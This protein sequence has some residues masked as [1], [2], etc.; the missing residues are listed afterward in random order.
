MPPGSQPDRP[1]ARGSVRSTV[2][3]E[4][5]VIAV[6]LDAWRAAN[7]LVVAILTFV[8]A[9]RLSE[10]VLARRNTRRLLAKG[11]VEVGRQHYLPMVVLHAC[12]LLGLWILA[13]A[14]GVSLPLLGIFALL[15]CA[16]LWVLVS[17]GER[18]TTRVIV[19]PGAPLVAS[20]PYRFLRH[21]NYCIVA[22]EIL[23]LPLAFGLVTFAVVFTAFNAII[24]SLRIRQEDAALRRGQPLALVDQ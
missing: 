11:A 18:W 7:P 9:Q 5:A 17:L 8:S 2:G 22:A 13:P 15:Q 1:D 24:L 6:L 16:R 20:G 14:G 3:F 4:D 10:L 23:V 19:L 12:W 21:P